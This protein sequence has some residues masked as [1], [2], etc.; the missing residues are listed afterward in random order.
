MTTNY[1]QYHEQ[2]N[3]SQA[4]YIPGK[5]YVSLRELHLLRLLRNVTEFQGGSFDAW[6]PTAPGY[7]LCRQLTGANFQ[8]V[9]NR[10][11][12]A[13]NAKLISYYMIYGWV[14]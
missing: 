2:V 12:W 1:H 14:S 3:P 9:F 6:G 8:S 7:E 10:Q 5:Q 13:S 4:W 11:L